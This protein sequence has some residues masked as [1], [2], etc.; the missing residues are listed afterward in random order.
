MKKD[1]IEKQIKVEIIVGSFMLAVFICLFIFTVILSRQAWFQEKVTF[2]CVFPHVNGLRVGDSVVARGMPIGKVSELKLITRDHN[3]HTNG[4][5]VTSLLDAPIELREGYRLAVVSSSIL[6][7]RIM[8]ID[9]GPEDAYPLEE[10]MVAYGDKPYDLINDTAKLLN[11]LKEDLTGE[12]GIVGN[13]RHSSQELD[14][15]VTRVNSGEGTLGKLLSADDTVYRDVQATA[16][17]LRTITASIEN[18]EG[19]LGQLVGDAE[20]ANELKQTLREARAAIDDF[21][22]TSPVVTFTSLFFG[23]F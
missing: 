19:V 12:G 5:L 1:W 14:E 6:G 7:G 10:G 23:A 9:E 2:E 21:R 8:E 13:L 20:M 4:V 3:A 15:I 11:S 22:E 17:S 16:A 18:K